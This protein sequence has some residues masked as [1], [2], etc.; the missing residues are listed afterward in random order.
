[1]HTTFNLRR[2]LAALGLGASLLGALSL[3]AVACGSPT[4]RPSTSDGGGPPVSV[5]DQTGEAGT[6]QGDGGDEELPGIGPTCQAPDAD[7]MKVGVMLPVA[8]GNLQMGCNAQVDTECADDEKP[9]HQVLVSSFDLDEYEVTQAQYFACVDARACTF[10]KCPW[11]PCVDPDLPISCV[12]HEQAATYCEWVGKRLPT[13]AEWERAAR[14]D[15]GRKYPWG[16]EAADCTRTNMD[17]CGGVVMRIGSLPAG[18]GP[19]GHKD[20]AGNVV[21][22]T[23]DFYAADYYAGSPP[24]DPK[25]PASG[26]HFVGRGG[27]FRSIAYWHRSSVRDSY[28]PNYSRV[29]MGFRCAK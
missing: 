10:P 23:A 19:Y 22:F 6:T 14:G 12:K 26:T 2:T 16:N 18:A 5:V 3:M 28:T 27:G 21:E 7:K 13:E 24:S 9:L 29:T 8:S 25:G 17:G 11:D 1:M 15:D 4:A 20:L